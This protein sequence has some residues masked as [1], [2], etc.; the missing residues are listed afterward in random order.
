MEPSNLEIQ[1]FTEAFFNNLKCKLSWE[2]ESLRITEIP[3]DFE[4]S[5]CTNKTYRIKRLHSSAS[6]K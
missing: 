5:I 3:A 1:K 6:F 2:N 4:E